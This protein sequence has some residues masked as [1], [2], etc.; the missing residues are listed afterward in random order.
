MKKI[1]R[2][3]HADSFSRSCFFLQDLRRRSIVPTDKYMAEPLL[4]QDPFDILAFWK[5]NTDKYPIL[6]Q[7]A[8]DVMSIQVST[9]ASESAFSAAGQVV[10]PYR[11]RLDP[12]M[13]Q[14]LI[15][16]KDWIRAS[17]KGTHFLIC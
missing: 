1:L 8:R 13:V 17:R 14:A 16:T 10:D 7:I 15:C 12:E 9:V 4:K 11:N 2:S 3:S 6:S 5:N